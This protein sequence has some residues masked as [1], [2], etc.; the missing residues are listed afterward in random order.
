MQ[1]QQEKKKKQKKKRALENTQ[2][3]RVLRRTAG[4]TERFLSDSK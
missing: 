3:I 2:R 1:M 4:K